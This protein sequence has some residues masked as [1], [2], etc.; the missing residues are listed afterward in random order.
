M[1]IDITRKEIYQVSTDDG[2]CCQYTRYSPTCWF[3]TMGESEEPVYDCEELEMDFQELMRGGEQTDELIKQLRLKAIS[4]ELPTTDIKSNG[5]SRA[6]IELELKLKKSHGR[7]F[8][9]RRYT[10]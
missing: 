5:E 9:A 7:R 8:K 2:E 6:A 1:I 3:V 4:F 10:V